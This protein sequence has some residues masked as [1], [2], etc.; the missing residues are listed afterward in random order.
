[1]LI[2]RHEFQIFADYGQFYL[3][4]ENYTPNTGDFWND[5]TIGQLLAVEEGFVAV[6]TARKA[7]VPV[8]IEIHDFEP[9]LEIENYSRVNECSLNVT[10]NKI[11]IPGCT[12]YPPD[13]ARIEIEPH[14]YRVRV[15]YG[16]LESVADEF[17]G[18]DFYVLQL[19]KNSEMKQ[20]ST[21]KP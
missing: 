2:S 20:I 21:L 12:D 4:D 15:L 16:N 11:V 8:T 10:S 7:E 9:V 1:M 3:E 5:E 17:E 13:A 14:I 19:W 6:G 18:E